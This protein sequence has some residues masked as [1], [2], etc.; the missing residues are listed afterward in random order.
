MS[1][2]FRDLVTKAIHAALNFR[3]VSACPDRHWDWASPRCHE[4]IPAIQLCYAAWLNEEVPYIVTNTERSAFLDLKTD[5]DRDALIQNFW[6]IR[7]PD[8]N[9]P[10]NEFRDEY[11]R[12]LAC[13][14]DQFGSP[15]RHDGWRTDRGMVYI[16]LGPPQRGGRPHLSH[17]A[18]Q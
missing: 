17:A 16:T 15:G 10:T 7:N 11:Y 8:P 2:G 4:E 18:A 13:A 5:A 3:P 1:E 12:R 14:N 9:S 6:A